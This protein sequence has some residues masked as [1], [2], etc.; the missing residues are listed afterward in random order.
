M[1]QAR[2]WQSEAIAFLDK[3]EVTV[4]NV[5]VNPAFTSILGALK[6]QRM[7]S[8]SVHAAAALVIGRRAWGYWK[9]KTSTCRK[10]TGS[11]WT[12]NSC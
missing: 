4:L 5:K 8:L 11:E 7:L 10:R 12:A 6:Y 2:E 3:E 9:G 1:G